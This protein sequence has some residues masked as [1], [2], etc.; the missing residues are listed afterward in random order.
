MSMYCALGSS[1]LVQRGRAKTL[2]VGRALL[3]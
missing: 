2:P 1:G 3:N